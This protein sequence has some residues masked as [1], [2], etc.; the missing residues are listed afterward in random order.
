MLKVAGLVH[1]AQPLVGSPTWYQTGR[2]AAIVFPTQV[3]GYSAASRYSAGSAMPPAADSLRLFEQVR[4]HVYVVYRMLAAF[5]DVE[6]L[7]AEQFD[8]LIV[9]PDE[10]VQDDLAGQRV[11]AL[12]DIM[13]RIQQGQLLG[14]GEQA[15]P[16]L[17]EFQEQTGLAASH[18][19]ARL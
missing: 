2:P 11:V 14:W 9:L 7:A 15:A 5:P 18:S 4:V 19:M 1:L 10:Y 3:V 12:P 6:M 13:T 8:G 17:T 16:L